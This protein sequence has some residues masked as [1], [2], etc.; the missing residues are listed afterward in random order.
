LQTDAHVVVVTDILERPLRAVVNAGLPNRACLLKKKIRAGQTAFSSGTVITS[1]AATTLL[2]SGR[3]LILQTLEGVSSVIGGTK[4]AAA[5][6]GL[7]RT[8]LINNMR[9]TTCAGQ[10]FPG[11]IPKP[12]MIERDWR[13]WS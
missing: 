5:K 8:T 1:P 6:L 7:K 10:G 9:R 13:K 3:T 2:D 12:D 4:G 11:L